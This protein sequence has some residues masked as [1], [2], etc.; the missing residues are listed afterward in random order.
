MIARAADELGLDRLTLRSVADHLGVSIAALYHHVDGKD[1]LVRLV[2]EYSATSIPRPSDHGQHW[3]RWLLEWAR[4]NR[5]VFLAQ[6]ALLPQ[7]MEGAISDELIA[8]NLDTILGAM[9]REGFTVSEAHEAYELVSSCAIGAA[10]AGIREQQATKAGR[11]ARAAYQQVLAMA[12]ADE[13]PHLR[14]LVAL[15]PPDERQFESE[16]ATVLTGIAV[17]RGED[18]RT[19]CA[20]AEEPGV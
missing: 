7:Y 6:P 5:D 11:P 3:A 2:A 12:G 13:L 9:V 18:W 1:D 10:V 17:R 19:I 16:V 4:Y 8:G 14:A 15:G 20:A